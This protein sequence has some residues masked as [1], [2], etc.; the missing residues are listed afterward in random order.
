[1]LQHALVAFSI[2]AIVAPFS[3]YVGECHSPQS[4]ARACSIPSLN[5]TLM[6]HGC[7]ATD[8]EHDVSNSF[9][10]PV[11]FKVYLDG[12]ITAELCTSQ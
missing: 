9:Y 8:A 1:M 3:Y 7:T 4:A 10:L 6:M 5:T 2:A 12:W 11:A